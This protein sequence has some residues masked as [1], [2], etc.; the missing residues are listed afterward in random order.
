MNSDV[1]AVSWFRRIAPE[2][3]P[4]LECLLQRKRLPDR[5]AD[6]EDL[7]RG[8]ELYFQDRHLRYHRLYF[9]CNASARTR[10]IDEQPRYFGDQ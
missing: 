1:A 8:C 3:T 9:T 2:L 4:Q 6:T 5:P 7:Q 10:T